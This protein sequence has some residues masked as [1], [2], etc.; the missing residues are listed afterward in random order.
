DIQCALPERKAFEVGRLAEYGRKARRVNVDRRRTTRAY[1]LNAAVIDCGFSLQVEEI[2]VLVHCHG[3]NSG[4]SLKR[5]LRAWRRSIKTGP[6]YRVCCEW[7]LAAR[8]GD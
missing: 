5:S 7:T 1:F 2:A 8:G 4:M 6:S 3:S